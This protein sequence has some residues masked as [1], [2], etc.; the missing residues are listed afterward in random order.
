[1][2]E[3]NDFEPTHKEL[4]ATCAKLRGLAY[5]VE[6]CGDDPCPP[7]DLGEAFYG[8]GLILTQLHVELIAIARAL[9]RQ[10]LKRVRR[11]EVI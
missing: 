8:V 9:E 7:P 5:L 4:R 11:K 2:A 1:M 6:Q 3:T 10:D